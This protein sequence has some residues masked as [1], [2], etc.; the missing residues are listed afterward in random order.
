MK[1]LQEI[2]FNCIDELE[3]RMNEERPSSKQIKHMVYIL[4]WKYVPST[5]TDIID[6]AIEHLDIAM[7]KPRWSPFKNDTPIGMMKSN[8]YWHIN[9]QLHEFVTGMNIAYPKQLKNSK[10]L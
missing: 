9:Q 5:Y 6:I 8:I 4:S 3:V 10:R 2:I 1:S 7:Q